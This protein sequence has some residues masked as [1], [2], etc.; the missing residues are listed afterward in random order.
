MTMTDY[1][2]DLKPY[3]SESIQEALT[4]I[5]LSAPLEEIRIRANQPLQLIFSGYERLIYGWGG[6]A[7]ANRADLDEMV[8]RLC[9]QSVYAYSEEL[10]SGFITLA[11]G[12][13]IGLT[14]RCISEDGRLLR[15]T[16]ITSINIRIPRSMIGAAEKLLSALKNG[17]DGYF[18]TL[19]FS[20]PCCGKTTFLRD[21]IRMAANGEPGVR[22]QKICV[23]D[24]RYE[25][26]GSVR[27]AAGFDLGPRTDVRT[28]GEKAEGLRSMLLTMSPDILVTDELGTK[29]EAD[30]V[31]EA[32]FS[33]V[34][35]FSSAHAGSLYELAARP[36][37]RDLIR[38]RVFERYV[39]LGRS[40]GVGTVEAL[41]GQNGERLVLR[42]GLWQ[43]LLQC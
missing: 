36:C 11:G 4:K 43:K 29:E 39:M 30:A 7:F 12:Y 19:V 25:L 3:L 38:N 23:V 34:T 14:G 31:L 40:C 8:A 16:D 26:A 37:Y 9:E 5:D 27:G 21:L 13:R 20:E 18:T 2:A 6:R 10:K 32:R 22:P 41:Y 33:G 17:H 1:R 35:V 24:T 42:E 15:M 28:G